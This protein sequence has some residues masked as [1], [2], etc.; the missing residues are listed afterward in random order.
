LDSGITTA[1]A[2]IVVADDNADM[3]GYIVRLLERHWRVEAVGDGEAAL[4]AIRRARPTSWLSDVMMP[5]L[6]GIALTRA[7]RA[8]AEL[9]SL[10]IILVSARAGEEARI[11][12]VDAQA[13]DY[14]TKPFSAR[15]LV[16]RVNVHLEL[17]RV[18][19]ET[20]AAIRASE[21]RFRTFV[22]ASTDAVY[23][24]SP[25][26]VRDAVPRRP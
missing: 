3:R 20:E 8:D 22:T 9:A 24:M 18:R 11:E 26:L 2:R 4:A 17:Q 21:Q 23:R 13:D 12:G 19:R 7:I 25:G 10:P 16:A 5:R 6:D 1:G 14:L 15:D